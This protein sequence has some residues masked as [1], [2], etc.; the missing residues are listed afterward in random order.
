MQVLHF[1]RS[2]PDHTYQIYKQIIEQV[3][4]EKDLGIIIDN[5]LK[6][7]IFATSKAMHMTEVIQKTFCSMS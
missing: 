2:A 4:E 1:G 6:F 3:T 5:Q 7:F